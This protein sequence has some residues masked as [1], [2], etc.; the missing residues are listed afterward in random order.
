VGISRGVP[1]ER[2]R[3]A[4][5]PPAPP[6]MGRSSNVGSRSHRPDE[7]VGWLETRDFGE[8]TVGSLFKEAF[9]G[10]MAESD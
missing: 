6:E 8:E 4:T 3:R 10:A 7:V 1:R 9:L 5:R 2:L